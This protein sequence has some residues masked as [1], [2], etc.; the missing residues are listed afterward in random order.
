M[1]AFAA[2]LPGPI[3]F[4]LTLA[5]S[6][7]ADMVENLITSNGHRT[8][9]PIVRGIDRSAP[10]ELTGRVNLTAATKD[11]AIAAEKAIRDLLSV[12]TTLTL[13]STN[14]TNTVTLNVLA[15]SSIGGVL[16]A[17]FDLG[18]V[19]GWQA[20]IHLVCEPYAMAPEATPVN[21]ANVTCPN[22]QDVTVTGEYPTPLQVAVTAVGELHALY[23]GVLPDQTK[24]LT[25]LLKQ[26]HDLFQAL[27]QFDKPP[28]RRL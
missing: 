5:D 16:D 10:R 27:V 19:A 25:D 28:Q 22:I 26:A 18:Y 8:G 11:A 1:T 23:I 20:P 3:T 13:Q 17:Q 15:G 4:A 7:I 12:G 9:V 6:Q 21:A 24:A 2:T 14:A